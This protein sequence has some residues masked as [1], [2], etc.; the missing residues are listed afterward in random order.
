MPSDLASP[1]GGAFLPALLL[2]GMSVAPSPLSQ[3]DC[4]AVNRLIVRAAES[5]VMPFYRST[6]L[7]VDRKSDNSAVTQADRACSAF[8]EEALPSLLPGSRVMSEEAVET[9]G[10]GQ[11]ELLWII[12]PVDGT[13]PFSLGG[14]SFA[15][16]IALAWRGRVVR[17]WIYRPV[18]KYLLWFD[19]E[20]TR[21]N[22]Q[23]LRYTDCDLSW[24]GS[25]EMCK[26]PITYPLPD[27]KFKNVRQHSC[28]NNEALM[29]AFQLSEFFVTDYVNPWDTAAPA[30]I[31][32]GLGGVVRYADGRPYD[33]GL[34][35][36]PL[37]FAKNPVHWEQLAALARTIYPAFQVQ[38]GQ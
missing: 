37:I 24:Y 4:L 12:D 38:P 36:T 13:K 32:L 9:H 25:L 17:S 14:V 23:V 33:L 21:L 2:G 10:R 30:G 18:Q 7:V 29:L 15:V 19:G 16:M 34:T 1:S 3:L 35:Q 26:A 28:A 31:N 20:Y 6:E 5:C 27:R 11:D 8:L 22:G